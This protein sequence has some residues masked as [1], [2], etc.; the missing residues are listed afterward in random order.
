MLMPGDPALLVGV[1]AERHVH[2][3]AG[4]PVHGLHAVAGRPDAVGTPG[5][6]HPQV[7]AD[8]AGDA[9]REPGVL[10]ERGVR[11]YAQAEHHDVGRQRAGRR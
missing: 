6:P 3:L 2:R 1:R 10:G 5:H 8:A 4:D 11:A 9:E 7:G